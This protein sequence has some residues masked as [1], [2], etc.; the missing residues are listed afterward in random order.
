[1]FIESVEKVTKIKYKVVTEN[2]LLYLYTGD[3]R[4]YRIK[5][6]TELSDDAYE[7]LM[8]ETLIPRCRRKALDILT[9]TD[10]TEK[11]LREKL[12]RAGFSPEL[13]ND[14]ISYVNSYHYLDDERVAKNYIGFKG[15]KKSKRELSMEL[16][17][18]GIERDT[19]E[20][21]IEEKSD[22]D[23]AIE[24]VIRKRIGSKEKL[25][26]DEIRK[27]SGYLYRH[28]FEADLIKDKLYR[29]REENNS[30]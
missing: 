2:G 24:S 19:A 6:G 13:V 18:K 25:S 14:A 10:R 8:K 22:E 26:D 9:R 17:R 30:L 4:R 23:S 28:G 5:Q 3:L 7:A 20:R 27:L 12:A 29:L 1:M 16:T 11:E 21:L 15:T